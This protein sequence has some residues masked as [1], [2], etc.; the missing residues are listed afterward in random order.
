[1]L[2]HRFSYTMEHISHYTMDCALQIFL[3]LGVLNV[4]SEGWNFVP[5]R[6]TMELM[7]A[8]TYRQHQERKEATKNVG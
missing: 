5:P 1:M 3:E 8:P 7:D 2:T 4:S 6:G